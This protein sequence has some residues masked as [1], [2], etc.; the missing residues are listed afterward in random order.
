[1]HNF[2]SHFQW[3]F[4]T[5]CTRPVRVHLAMVCGGC[6]FD[7]FSFFLLSLKRQQNL[8]KIMFSCISFPI[9]PHLPQIMKKMYFILVN[10]MGWQVCSGYRAVWRLRGWYRLGARSVETIHPCSRLQCHFYLK[11]HHACK[12][13]AATCSFGRMTGIACKLLQQQGGGTDTKVRVSTHLR[14]KCLPQ[15]NLAELTHC[16]NNY[17]QQDERYFIAKDA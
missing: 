1:M 11:L 16:G 2:K 8:V 12:L 9:W 14:R 7:S 4:L 6:S 15:L 17:D 10:C 5:Y 13:P 3:D